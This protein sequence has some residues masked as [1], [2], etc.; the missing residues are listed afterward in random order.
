L[1]ET[2]QSFAMIGQPRAYLVSRKN[3]IRPGDP[4]GRPRALLFY[5]TALRL[6]NRSDT[7]LIGRSAKP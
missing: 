6:M 4:G 1:D 3:T 5:K 2:A 7:A